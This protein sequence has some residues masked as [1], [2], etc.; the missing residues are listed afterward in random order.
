MS[1]LPTIISAV[2]ES[3]LPT[4][5]TRG[6]VLALCVWGVPSKGSTLPLMGRA[7]E[8]WSHTLKCT[9]DRQGEGASDD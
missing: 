7:G 6:E 1:V 2:A 3:P 4:S 5:P 9:R 8:G